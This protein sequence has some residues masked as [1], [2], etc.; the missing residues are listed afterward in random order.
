MED[1]GYNVTLQT[2]KFT[3]LVLRRNADVQR[4]RADARR[5]SRSS[6]TGIPG[7]QRHTT[8]G[9]RPAGRRHRAS[10]RRRRSSSTSGCTAAD[11]SGFTAGSIALI[12]RGGCNFG[13]KV[14]NAQAAGAIGVVIFNEGNP[15]RTGVISG[16]LLDANDNPFVPTIPVAFTSFAI[17]QSLLQRVPAAGD[18]AGA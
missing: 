10:R 4:E 6:T 16:S 2:Y 9:D 5:T 11:F 18:A 17:G 3:V 13:V 7:E 1:A 12:Q 14:L 15:G 8:D